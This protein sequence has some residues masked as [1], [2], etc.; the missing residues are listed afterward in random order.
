[1]HNWYYSETWI[2]HD[3]RYSI[4]YPPNHIGIVSNSW[5]RRILPGQWPANHLSTIS[6]SPG[7]PAPPLGPADWPL[8]PQDHN[9]FTT[10]REIITIPGEVPNPFSR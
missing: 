5:P 1:M 9:W 8:W 10:I 2:A 7:S 4:V 6:N 3:I